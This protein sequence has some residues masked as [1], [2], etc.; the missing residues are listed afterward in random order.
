MEATTAGMSGIIVHVSY[1]SR[2]RIVHVSYTY[3]TCKYRKRIVQVS[4]TYRTRVVQVS[5]TY[6]TCKYRK[7]IVQVSYTYRTRVVHV[8][9]TYRT[10]IVHVSY[11]CRTRIVHVSYTYRTSIV[12]VSYKYRTRIVTRIVHVSYMQVSYT[13]RTSIVHASIVNV[14]YRTRIVQVSYTYRTSIVHVSYT[15]R[16][17]IV[18]V[19]YMQVS[20]TYRTSIVHVSYTYRTRIVHASYTHRTRIVHVS[21]TYRTRIVHV[22]YM[23]VSYTYR[24]RIVHA[25]YTYRTRIV[26]VSYTYRTCKYRK[27]IVQ[28]SYTYR[29]C[30]YRKRI[31]QVSYTYHT[32][33]YRTR[34]VRVSYAYRTRIVRVSY[35]YRTRIV[36]VSYAYRTRIVRVSYAYRTRIVRV[37]YAYRTR[38]VHVLYTYRTPVV[39]E[40]RRHEQ[41]AAENAKTLCK[42]L[43]INRDFDSKSQQQ[44][45][46]S[47]QTSSQTLG[48]HLE[49]S[50]G[51]CLKE[52]F[53]SIL[54]VVVY[55]FPF[56][57]SFPDLKDLYNTA[58]DK[59]IICGPSWNNKYPIIKVD[60]Q[61]GYYAYEC[62]GRAIRKFPGFQGY[63]YINDDMV[64]NWWNFRHLNSSKI[65]SGAELEQ[66]VEVGHPPPT[67]WM[68]WSRRLPGMKKCEDSFQEIQTIVGNDSISWMKDALDV[69]LKNH[70]GFHKVL[71]CDF[72]SCRKACWDVLKRRQENIEWGTGT[73]IHGYTKRK[74]GRC[75]A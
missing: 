71:W 50:K 55:H 14:S 21:Y 11:T 75:Q 64:V 17:R 62:L 10:R 20:Y 16:T 38:I 36:R 63:W 48:V 53:S 68:W 22:L 1:T 65:W 13:Y 57:E 45:K 58:F 74:H 54:L 19:S 29:T 47:L 46:L 41:V 27:R 26:H 70:H 69:H 30:K 40:T 5:Y 32:R 52:I 37:S 18:H 31:V 67:T 23:Q 12:H 56:Y 72:T 2:T 28:V 9:Y 61:N 6:R 3:R 42:H 15:Y 73:G 51:S 33:T 24:T 43:A 66:G 49:R 60:I 7:R 59:I 35:A 25:S 44:I 34:I 8:S 4:Y 39:I